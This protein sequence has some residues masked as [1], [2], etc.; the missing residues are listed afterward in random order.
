VKSVKDK[1]AKRQAILRVLRFSP[2]TIFPSTLHT[3]L[4]LHVALTRRTNGRS[5]GTFQKAKRFRKSRGIGRRTPSLKEQNGRELNGLIGSGQGQM[6]G[7]CQ[8]GTESSGS[9]KYGKC[10]QHLR[11]NDF[12][13][14]V[15]DACCNTQ[16]VTKFSNRTK[17]LGRT[18]PDGP[19]QPHFPNN[20]FR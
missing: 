3:H 5:L 20:T 18:S 4:H 13:K 15:S 12:T 14:K 11:N 9:I 2:V 16:K 17:H 19:K 6:A 10:L 8:H 7:S 1:V